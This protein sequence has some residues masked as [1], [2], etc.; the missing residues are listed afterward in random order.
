MLVQNAS[1]K[2]I[3]VQMLDVVSVVADGDDGRRAPQ[4]IIL[5]VLSQFLKAFRTNYILSSSD[6]HQVTL[7]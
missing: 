1:P 5:A 4:G 7:F 3:Q 6:P 2:R